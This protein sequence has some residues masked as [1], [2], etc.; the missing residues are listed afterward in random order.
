MSKCCRRNE[1]SRSWWKL[2]YSLEVPEDKMST[3]MWVEVSKGCNSTPTKSHICNVTVV[4]SNSPGTKIECT[5]CPY[6]VWEILDQSRVIVIECI[7]V[8]LIV[9]VKLWGPC[10]KDT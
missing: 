8:V 4:K 5:C 7:L 10:G 6:A 1:D 3:K 2:D 9:P